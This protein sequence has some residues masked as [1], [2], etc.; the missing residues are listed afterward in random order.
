MQ[1]FS[2]FFSCLTWSTIMMGENSIKRCLSLFNFQTAILITCSKARFSNATLEIQVTATKKFTKHG[3]Q[4]VTVI[5]LHQ[6]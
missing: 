6:M 3:M 2:V 5:C 4:T 1:I